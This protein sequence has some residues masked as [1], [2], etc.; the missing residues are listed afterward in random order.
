MLAGEECL[1]PSKDELLNHRS[2]AN[3]GWHAPLLV[4]DVNDGNV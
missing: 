1:L 2:T 4:G 3:M